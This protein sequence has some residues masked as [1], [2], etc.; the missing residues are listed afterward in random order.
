MPRNRYLWPPVTHICIVPFTSSEA[1]GAGGSAPFIPFLDAVYVLLFVGQ[2][3]NL[4]ECVDWHTQTI[5]AI[6][7]CRHRDLP[8]LGEGAKEG[9]CER[10]QVR[11][12]IK[13]KKKKLRWNSGGGRECSRVGWI[14][15][16]GCPRVA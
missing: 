3:L 5:P 10:E 13:K 16:S 6:S 7:H 12:N 8:P 14:L 2:G 9:T 1:M 15:F 4:I 11:E